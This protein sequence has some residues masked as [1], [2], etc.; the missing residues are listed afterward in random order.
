MANFKK[1]FKALQNKVFE[2]KSKIKKISS[3][4]ELDADVAEAVSLFNS[5]AACAKPKQYNGLR[6]IFYRLDY[7]CVLYDDLKALLVKHLELKDMSS[8]DIWKLYIE[9]MI[10]LFDFRCFNY[11][12]LIEP[13]NYYLANVK[14][15]SER[16]NVLLSRMVL[17]NNDRFYHD[18]PFLDNTYNKELTKPLF[19]FLKPALN[20]FTLHISQEE[21]DAFKD[22]YNKRV[23]SFFKD[24]NKPSISVTYNDKAKFDKPKKYSTD[25]VVYMD[26]IENDLKNQM[27]TIYDHETTALKLRNYPTPFNLYFYLLEV[28]DG[29]EH[30]N[31]LNSL[32]FD[33]LNNVSLRTGFHA[34]YLS[35]DD[36]FVNIIS[37]YFMYYFGI[38]YPKDEIKAM[39]YLSMNMQTLI[40]AADNAKVLFKYMPYDLHSIIANNPTNSFDFIDKCLN[41]V[42]LNEKQLL[43]VLDSKNDDKQYE[44]LAYIKENN[45]YI[46]DEVVDIYKDAYNKGLE[47]KRQKD[48]ELEREAELERQKE[49][50]EQKKQRKLEEEQE[51]KAKAAERLKESLQ[52][53]DERLSDEELR[54]LI[55]KTD[56]VKAMSRVGAHYFAMADKDYRHYNLAFHYYNI[57]GDLGNNVSYLNAAIAKSNYN[58]FL[59]KDSSEYMEN[60]ALIMNTLEKAPHKAGYYFVYAFYGH[61]YKN[62]QYTKYIESVYKEILDG[63]NLTDFAENLVKSAYS[64]YNDDYVNC[65][66]YFDNIK[67]FVDKS[68][69]SIFSNRLY[70]KLYD[71]T[72]NVKHPPT[73]DFINPFS[74]EYSEY[75]MKSAQYQ[76]AREAITKAKKIINWACSL[77]DA[78]SYKYKAYCLYYGIMNFEKNHKEA[79]DIFVKYENLF[80]ANENTYKNILAELKKEFCS[81]KRK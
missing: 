4:S 79:Y 1:E 40:K 9:E 48:L 47:I 74:Q 59:A 25:V 76:T 38:G 26:M 35:R 30:Y 19:D 80:G 13:V 60:H 8:M 3:L 16:H 17:Y 54:D 37:K 77:G 42:Y 41:I 44:L 51:K 68:M 12:V 22:E 63:P 33:I 31:G 2:I 27:F 58:K 70:D 81:K 39:E 18:Y 75:K 62:E 64:F 21:K 28:L 43:K 36:L 78:A 56:D 10:L 52:S 7:I 6:F 15:V 20:G 29:K 53:N 55:S 24:V 61:D 72:K 5:A 23:F 49:M 45:P 50:E 32:I 34:P 46:F 14:Y 71:A 57:A 11:D 66:N 67:E 73:Q 65:L 69:L